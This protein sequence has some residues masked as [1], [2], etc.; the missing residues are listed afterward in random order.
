MC[1]SVKSH[2]TSG[3]SVHREN[4]ATYSECNEGQKIVAFSLKLRRCRATALP[5]LYATVQSA[6]FSQRNMR[7]RF[8][9]G[10]GLGCRRLPQVL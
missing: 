6:I 4:A 2:L 3:A 9:V 5:E 10:R 1:V 8:Y 7:V